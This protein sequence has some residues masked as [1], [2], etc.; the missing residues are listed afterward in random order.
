MWMPSGKDRDVSRLS[1]QC[2][3]SGRGDEKLN[4]VIDDHFSEE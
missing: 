2:A 4:I 3:E 1:W